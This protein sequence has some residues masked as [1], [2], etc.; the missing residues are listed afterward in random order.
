MEPGAELRRM[1]TVGH[2]EDG[3]EYAGPW[4]TWGP[5]LSERAWGTV[6]E[7]Y[8]ADGDAW[9]SFPHD[10]ARSRAYRWNEDGLAGLSDARQDLCLG[11]R[12]VERRGP[13]PQ[14]AHLRAHRTRGQ[15]RRGRQGVLVVPRRHAQPLLDAVALPLPAG[16]RS[17]TTT[18]SRRTAGAAATSPSTSW[19]TPAS[20]TTTAT[21]RS[22][23]TYAKA[24][25]TDLLH[26]D[27]ASTNDGP[28]AATLHVLPT[29]WFRNTWAWERGA[30]PSR[31]ARRWRGRRPAWPT[32]R[33]PG[34]TGW[35]PRPDRTA[36]TRAAVL[37]QRDQRAAAVR[38]RAR[39]PAYPKD[40]INDHVVHGAATVNPDAHGHQGGLAGTASTS[41]AGRDRS[42]C[43]LRLCV[44]TAVD[45]P[46]RRWSA[47][48]FDEVLAAARPR[49]TSSTP[50]L[51]PAGHVADEAHVV[52]RQAFA[53]TGVGQAVLPLRRRRV[54]RRRPGRP[55][56]A[57]R[58]PRTGATPAGG[59]STP[60]T[61]SRCPTRG[62][63]RG[64]R[65]GTS[66]STRS[67]SRTSTR[68]SRST[69]CCCCAASGSCTPTARSRRTS[70]RSTTSTRRCTPGPRCRCSRS[71][72]RRDYD[73]LERVLHEAAAELHLVG[74][75]QGPRGQQRV[76]GRLPRA[77]QHRRRSTGR[78]CLRGCRLEQTDGT[79]WMAFYA[80]TMLRIALTLAEQTRSYEDLVTKFFEH[81]VTITD[82]IAR[83]RALGRGGRL[84]LRPAVDARRQPYAAAGQV[85]GRGHP[86]ARRRSR[87]RRRAS[88][89]TGCASGSPTSSARRGIDEAGVDACGFVRR[90]PDRGP[91]L[92]SMVDPERLRRVLVGGARRGRH[93]V[94]VRHPV[95]VARGTCDEPFS[96][97]VDGQT[98]EI[99]YEPAESQHRRCTAATPTGAGRCGS[100]QP[101]GRR[102]ARTLRRATSATLHGRVPDRVRPRDHPGR[103]RRR[104][105]HA[106]DLVCSCPDRTGRRPTA[107]IERFRTD[108]RWSDTVSFFEY[109]DGDHGYGLGA[110]HQ[111][112]WTALVADLI[113]RRPR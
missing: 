24:D 40:G 99:G 76:R 59:T 57:A 110:S 72:A 33:W 104:A 35:R 19:S 82:G 111:T 68:R 29:L 25:P 91:L 48:R 101:P 20:S 63:T 30:T 11:A 42:S 56:A 77:G 95:A 26:A 93:A 88:P 8:S 45:A 28:E 102:G 84:L 103:G 73:F 16:A 61:S 23:S 107:G 51:T 98:F 41:P 75:P 34:R 89:A 7:D 66:P 13:D 39:P 1:A 50:T 43:R 10:H 85:P 106:A 69:S 90:R 17:R 64:S 100:R 105:A 38:R 70:G 58:A 86:G 79:A 113:L 97:V 31:R 32:T 49:P 109:F 47:P 36:P 6:R 9:D 5:Y 12:A 21:G 87:C 37:R 22:R 67:R 65:P 15:P 112:G 14:G 3:L 96:V 92:L 81:F 2:P 83:P 27:H 94:P 46:T 55:A 44:P 18:W 4:Y 54:A 71:T 53:G 80:L 52:A 74:Q 108:P 78:T 60:T 62:S